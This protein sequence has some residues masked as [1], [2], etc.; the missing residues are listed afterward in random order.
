MAHTTNPT[1]EDLKAFL[2]PVMLAVGKS[3]PKQ[4]NY[5]DRADA[6][7]LYIEGQIGRPILATTQT[8]RYDPPTN[9]R[10][11][12]ELGADLLSVSSLTVEGITMVENTDFVLEPYNAAA[13]GKPF[14]W[15]VFTT[16][17]W[18]YR[19][20]P[21]QF[22]SV[23]ITGTWGLSTAIQAQL[24]QACLCQGAINCYPELALAISKG[25]QMLKEG[26]VEQMYA[27]GK[28]NGPLV[29]EMAGWQLQVDQAINNAL[30]VEVG[31]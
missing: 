2:E 26:D 5:Q 20:M 21:T 31:L 17:C 25:L 19:L 3:L 28:G 30:L 7:R 4:V 23:V 10:R 29:E 9:V 15:I 12:L 14:R 22:R 13:D 18:P 1:G 27:R 11:T 16:R 6:A 24:W 8:R